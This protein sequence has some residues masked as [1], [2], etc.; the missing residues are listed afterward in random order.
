MCQQKSC[1]QEKFVDKNILVKMHKMYFPKNRS[2]AKIHNMCF[3]KSGRRPKCTKCVFL[4]IG[5]PRSPKSVYGL[6][7]REK[8]LVFVCISFFRGVYYVRF[9]HVRRRKCHVLTKCPNFSG[10][11]FFCKTHF[12]Y[13][14]C[15]Q[16]VWN[17]GTHI[18]VRHKKCAQNPEMRS[19]GDRSEKICR[20][21]WKM[22]SSGERISR[23]LGI[24]DDE[25]IVFQQNVRIFPEDTFFCKTRFTYKCYFQGVRMMCTH[26]FCRTQKIC[27]KSR[28]VCT[29]LSTRKKLSV[30]V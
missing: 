2:P 22:H 3:L 13:K 14:C 19:C 17:V 4:K 7:A 28:N 24:P 25:T 23:N 11:P 12:V 15:F 9:R 21:L 26:I 1:W 20:F 16:G 30:F 10:D 29:R 27:A 6:S 8:L 5:L 18:F